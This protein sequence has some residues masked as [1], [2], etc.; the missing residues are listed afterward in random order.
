MAMQCV[1]HILKKEGYAKEK[2][3][4]GSALFGRGSKAARLLAGGLSGRQE[5][6]LTS[7]A[8]GELTLL[9]LQATAWVMI[10]GAMAIAKMRKELAR[11]GELIL[12]KLG[13][14]DAPESLPP[15]AL[16][17][18]APLF[19]GREPGSK[20]GY[21]ALIIAVMLALGFGSLILIR[22]LRGE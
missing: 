22:M 12:S 13:R 8:E 9:S 18:F 19:T 14:G 7:T 15:D 16:G 4:P 1:E 11:L 20:H 3:T 17:R 2:S 21:Q 5:F 6:R 10:G